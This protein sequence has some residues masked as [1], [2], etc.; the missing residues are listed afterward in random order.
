M[1]GGKFDADINVHNSHTITELRI[2]SLYDLMVHPFKAKGHCV[3]MDSAYM[4]NVICQ[5][6]RGVL[7]ASLPTHKICDLIN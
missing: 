5:V 1:Y 4:G 2:V 3:V 6:G 7:T